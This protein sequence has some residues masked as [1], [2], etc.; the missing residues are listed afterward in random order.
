MELESKWWNNSS[1]NS[2]GTITSTVQADTTAGFSIV[3]YSGTGSN[4]TVGHGLGV[5]PDAVIIKCTNDS[6]NWRVYH[7]EEWMLQ[8]QKT[9][10]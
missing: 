8:L 3:Q 1:S 4:A 7:A 2:D 6:Q 10:L 5:A 9:M